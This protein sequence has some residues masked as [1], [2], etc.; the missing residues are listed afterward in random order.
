VTLH[1][2]Q[3]GPFLGGDWGYFEASVDGRVYVPI[4]RAVVAVKARGGGLHPRERG[5]PFFKRYFL[6]GSSTLRGWGRYE[7]SP[8]RNGLVIGGLGFFETSAEL[9]FPIRG[10]FS[11]VIFGEGGQVTERA[12][13]DTAFDLR[14]DVGLGLRYATRI[15]PVRADFGYQLN[16]IDGLLIG[17]RPE[18]RRWRIHVSVGQAF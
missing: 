1:L 10:A 2:E 3:A 17:G 18:A 12:W 6:G 5:V 14:T 15:G 7:V 11:G 13:D 16:P 8:L 9:R 4:G